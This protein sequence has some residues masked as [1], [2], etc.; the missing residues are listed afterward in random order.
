MHGGCGVTNDAETSGAND[1]D[2]PAVAETAMP[3]EGWF[4]PLATLL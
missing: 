2:S 4:L 1:S 3:W